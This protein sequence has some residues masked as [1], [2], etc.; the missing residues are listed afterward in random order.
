MNNFEKSSWIEKCIYGCGNVGANLCWTFMGMYITMY[1]TDSVGIAAAVAGTVMLVARLFDGVSD[2]IMAIIIEKTHFKLGKIRPWFLIAAPLLGISLYLSFHVPEGWSVSAKGIYVFI[3]YTF[4][5]AVSYT[6]YNL[7]YSSI[8]PLMTLDSEDRNKTSAVGNIITNA[9]MMVMNMATPLL[10]AANGGERSQNAWGMISTIYAVI[11]AVTIFL[12]GV[13]IKEKDV[14]VEN[15]NVKTKGIGELLKTVLTTKYTWVLMI[16]F[17]LYYGYNNMTGIR[18]Y[19]CRDVI[20]DFNVYGTA[21]TCTT[22]AMMIGMAATPKLFKLIGKKKAII[23]GM[24]LYILTSAVMFVVPQS[25]PVYIGA[26]I[27][28]GI[29]QAPVGAVMYVLIADLIDYIAV[30]KGVRAEGIVSMTSS[31]G[32]KIGSGLGSAAVGWGLAW[33]SYNGVAEMQTSATQ[34]GITILTTIVPIIISVIFIV[35]MSLWN[36]EKESVS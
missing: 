2:V 20:G 25:V 15:T 26:L 5:A 27:V 30:K 29:G 36:V 8:L 21:A 17:I 18:V 31:V 24:L 12:M 32:T 33:V 11:C 3:T 14:S 23:I 34:S 13:L 1:Y 19:F 7:A 10:L 22:L 4:T 16:L 9:G 35:V 28:Q 6:I